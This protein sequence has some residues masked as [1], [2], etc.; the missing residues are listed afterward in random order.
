M[1]DRAEGHGSQKQRRKQLPAAAMMPAATP[2]EHPRHPQPR[3]RRH[4][5]RRRRLRRQATSADPE[6]A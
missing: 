3:L 4:E 6:H 1:V 2:A 5:A